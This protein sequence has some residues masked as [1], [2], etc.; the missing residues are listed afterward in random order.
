M[1]QRG[2]GHSRTTEQA[3]TLPVQSSTI[4]KL[5][6]PSPP[7]TKKITS[8]VPKNSGDKKGSQTAK[9]IPSGPSV[10]KVERSQTAIPKPS[11][12]TPPVRT[13]KKVV[14]PDPVKPTVTQPVIPLTR[15]D[16]FKGQARRTIRSLQPPSKDSKVE[17]NPTT[18]QPRDDAAVLRAALFIIKASVAD[19]VRVESSGKSYSSEIPGRLSR[20]SF[21][22]LGRQP[23]TDELG[24]SRQRSLKA[25]ILKALQDLS[26]D[27]FKKITLPKFLS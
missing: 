15:E 7:T 11:R 27:Q 20:L 16:A 5:T 2:M 4:E 18:T 9:K 13:E 3:R 22:L 24:E 23:S 17:Q 19:E 14:S 10:Q 8:N 1:C 6:L 25:K 26:G 21:V 12:V